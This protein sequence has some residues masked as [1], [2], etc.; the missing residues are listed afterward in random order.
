M[1]KKVFLTLLGLFI[2]VQAIGVFAWGSYLRSQTKAEVISNEP[3]SKILLDSKGQLWVQPW[4]ATY[5]QDFKWKVYQ[6]GK[7]TQ[8]FDMS[9]PNFPAEIT[10]DFQGN[11]YGALGLAIENPGIRIVA[12]DGASW[13]QLAEFTP[14]YASS[15]AGIAASSQDNI[16]VAGSGGIFHYNG[17]EWQTFTSDNSALPS[18]YIHAIFIDSRERVWIGSAVGIAIIENGELQMLTGAAPSGVEIFSFAEGR[19]G[20]IWAGGDGNLYS[21]DGTQWMTHNARNSKL[22]GSRFYD[23]GTDSL[24]RVW[25]VSAEGNV[26]VFDGA[27]TRYLFGEPGNAIQAI[28]IGRDDTLYLMRTDDVGML[29][30]NVPLVNLIAL[31]FLWLLNNGVFIYLSIFLIIFWLAVAMNSWGIGLGLALGGLIFWGIEIFS[32]FDINGVPMGYLNPGFALTIF[33]F[34]GGLI[35]YFIKR[36]GVKYADFIGSGI[37]CVGGGILLACLLAVFMWGLMSLGA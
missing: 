33:T 28:E 12:F 34:I 24:N 16:W 19:D 37:G 29:R 13:N 32:L 3:P 15:I 1:L 26:S 25:A 18:A 27:T 6:D 5:S 14:G 10:K 36:R 23:I 4:A 22:K 2:L 8:T 21:F 31:K 20:K 7:L 17:R 35:G 11:L 30:A 9:D